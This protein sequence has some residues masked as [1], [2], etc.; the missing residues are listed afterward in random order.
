[1]T[2]HKFRC[3]T[4]N[5]KIVAAGFHNTEFHDTDVLGIF[6]ITADEVLK[7]YKLLSHP[8]LS[9]VRPDITP[10]RT[11][12]L[13][14]VR[15]GID[16]ESVKLIQNA[17]DYAEKLYALREIPIYKRWND[18]AKFDFQSIDCSIIEQSFEVR[19]WSK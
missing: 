10:Y 16:A 11:V 5:P 1:M 9:S 12:I 3:I 7:G 4:N 13:E 2:N 15:K 6:R 17:I 14:D 19:Q 18:K 8:L